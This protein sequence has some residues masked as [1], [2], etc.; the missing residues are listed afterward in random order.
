MRT[1]LIA[2]VAVP[3]AAIVASPAMAQDAGLYANVGL[4]EYTESNLDFNLFGGRIGYSFNPNFAIEAEGA[5]GTSG[6]SLGPIKVEVDGTLGAYGVA[7]LPVSE[8]V[9]FLARGGYQHYWVSAEG[10]AAALQGLEV[11]EDDGS[12]AVGVGM[13]AMVNANNGFRID[14]TTYV[15]GDN[16]SSISVSY[17]RRF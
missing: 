3:F 17:V 15:D 8:A 7:R 10:T 13:E 16:A 5:I 14:Y 9:S 6:E 4:S 2:F 11:S 12:F 1:R